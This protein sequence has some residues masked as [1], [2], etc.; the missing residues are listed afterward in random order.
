M[1]KYMFRAALNDEGVAGIIAE[2][3][4][5]RRK[6]ITGAVEKLGGKV[7]AFYFAFGDEDVIVIA[8]LPDNETAAAL[9]LETSASGRLTVSTTVLLTPE[10]IDRARE[11]KSGW[12]APGA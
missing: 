10:E 8:D 2:G 1:P 4:T 7:E 9:A 11:K 3:G 6:V 5:A 12:R